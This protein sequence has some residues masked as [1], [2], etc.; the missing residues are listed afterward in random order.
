MNL[1]KFKKVASSANDANI[2]YLVNPDKIKGI[3]TAS[4]TTDIF[5]APADGTNNDTVGD[6]IVI[7]HGSG[8]GEAITDKLLE[9]AY[10][11]KSNGGVPVTVDVDFFSGITDLVLTAV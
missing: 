6:K 2:A 9:F 11:N 8:D 4:T 7:T 1:L 10:G 5:L 3:V